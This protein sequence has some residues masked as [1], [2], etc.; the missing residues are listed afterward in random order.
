MR[1]GGTPASLPPSAPPFLPLP[2][3]PAL[4]PP[5]HEYMLLARTG[6]PVLAQRATIEYM[7]PQ[8][9]YR[10]HSPP[11]SHCLSVATVLTGTLLQG[12]RAPSQTYMAMILEKSANVGRVTGWVSACC[13]P[14]YATI[15]QPLPSVPG[16]DIR[17][18]N[19]SSAE[20]PVVNANLLSHCLL[21]AVYELHTGGLL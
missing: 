11:L 6:R 8:T 7:H 3:A 12:L 10:R 18:D 17:L 13:P 20:A 14:S 4:S 21:L 19:L 15:L 9:W 16:L 2:A 1:P 5:C